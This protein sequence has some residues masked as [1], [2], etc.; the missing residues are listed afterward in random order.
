LAAIGSEGLM[1]NKVVNISNIPGYGVKVSNGDILA[2][3]KQAGLD[4][5]ISKLAKTNDNVEV[6]SEVLKESILKIDTSSL[7]RLISGK[8][9]GGTIKTT[10]L[11]AKQASANASDMTKSLYSLV[12]QVKNGKGSAGILLRD[13]TLASSLKAVMDHAKSASLNADKAT[14]NANDLVSSLSYAVN[15][16]NG[17]LHVLLKDSAMGGDI[18]MSMENIRKGTAGFND[19]ME[20]LKHNF[21]LRGFFAKKEKQRQDSLKKTK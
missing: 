20:A 15:S 2:T 9:L 11:N 21:L 18:K 6:I 4:V 3:Q 17:P 10:L 14:A 12:Q 19:N 13:T 16:G 8:E 7:L 1:G 5:M